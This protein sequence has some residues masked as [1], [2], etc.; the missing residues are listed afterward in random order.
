[1]NREP[2]VVCLRWEDRCTNL[3]RARLEIEGTVETTISLYELS[4]LWKGLGAALDPSPIEFVELFHLT[5]VVNGELWEGLICGLFSY[6][7]QV[8]IQPPGSFISLKED[9]LARGLSDVYVLLFPYTRSECIP[10]LFLVAEKWRLLAYP[11]LDVG[12]FFPWIPF[13]RRRRIL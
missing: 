1:M 9:N 4:H 6:T 10:P 5:L 12:G 2:I 11:V 7:Y 13:G 3:R 8:I